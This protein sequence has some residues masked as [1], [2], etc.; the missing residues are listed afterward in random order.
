MVTTA[1]FEKSQKFLKKKKAT[2]KAF[3]VSKS[4]DA[5]QLLGGW[6]Y[7]FTGLERVNWTAGVDYWTGALEHWSL[8]VLQQAM[9][10]IL[11]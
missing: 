1:S 2:V 7:E 3:S 8:V 6:V 10:C 9:R 11:V 4:R 5:F